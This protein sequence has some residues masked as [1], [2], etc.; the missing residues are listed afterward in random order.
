MHGRQ[1]QWVEFE[2]SASSGQRGVLS[3]C[4]ALRSRRILHGYVD[5]LSD[6]RQSERYAVRRR[7]RVLRRTDT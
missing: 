6:G 5:Q 4:D 3:R 1:V 7:Q 2:L